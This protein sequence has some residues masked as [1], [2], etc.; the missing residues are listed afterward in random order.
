M[1][2]CLIGGIDRGLERLALPAAEAAEVNAQR[3]KLAAAETDDPRVR[4]MIGRSFV[5][6]YDVVLWV[7]AGLALAG[8]GCG[9]LMING[10][11]VERRDD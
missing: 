9:A 5:G 11:K 3:A 4:E 10:L 1:G 8:A 7:A 2:W 6:A